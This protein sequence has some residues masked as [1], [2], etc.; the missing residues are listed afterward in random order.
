MQPH[1]TPQVRTFGLSMM[2]LDIRQESTRH[3]E[4]M[5]CV[6]K[7]LGMGSYMEWDEVGARLHAL[8]WVL[9]LGGPLPRRPAPG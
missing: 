7:Y 6:T 3:A 4:V 8:A 9:C 5:D 1:H 2:R